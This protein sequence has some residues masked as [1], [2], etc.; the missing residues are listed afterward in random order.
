MSHSSQRNTLDQILSIE[1]TDTINNYNELRKLFVK[2]LSS[3]GFDWKVGKAIRRTE[4]LHKSI[5]IMEDVKSVSQINPALLFNIGEYLY[6]KRPNIEET[7]ISVD[8]QVRQLVD[9]YSEFPVERYEIEQA[10]KTL[11]QQTANLL[12]DTFIKQTKLPADTASVKGAI[13]QLLTAN[14]SAANA[15]NDISF[16]TN[17][18]ALSSK[19]HAEE[20]L[21]IENGLKGLRK[22]HLKN[23]LKGLEEVRIDQNKIEQLSSEDNNLNKETYWYYRKQN[24]LHSGYD[25]DK[26]LEIAPK[27]W[28]IFIRNKNEKNVTLPL[29]RPIK[30]YLKTIT[31]HL[32]N[33][34]EAKTVEDQLDFT[35]VIPDEALQNWDNTI[36]KEESILDSIKQQDERFFN[37]LVN[38]YKNEFNA[39]LIKVFKLYDNTLKERP[40]EI[41]NRSLAEVIDKVRTGKLSK[42]LTSTFRTF[43]IGVGVNQYRQE[44]YKKT[45]KPLDLD[46]GVMENIIEPDTIEKTHQQQAN[47]AKVAEYLGKIGA[48]CKELLEMKFLKGYNYEVMG[49]KL[50]KTEGSLR[51]QVSR[52]LDRLRKMIFNKS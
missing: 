12:S 4:Y 7:Q 21:H 18:I 41:Y 9:N 27:V 24:V 23:H 3:K 46:E 42:P 31:C 5:L 32:L 40:K 11:G 48:P 39:G 37:Q 52:C 16:T 51:T 50:G 10:L 8:Q 43:L 2:H 6:S 35:P 26:I 22:L 30:E 25:A 36:K 1:H 13:L 33:K 47:A 45:E 17:P 14:G 28:S 34:S 15:D 44:F 19:Q 29:N 20:L 38:D 49:V